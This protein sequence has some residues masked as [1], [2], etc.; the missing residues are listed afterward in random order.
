MKIILCPLKQKERQQEKL[1]LCRTISH[2]FIQDIDVMILTPFGS[3]KRNWISCCLFIHSFSSHDAMW[4]KKVEVETWIFGSKIFL[5]ISL[6]CTK[7]FCRDVSQS[8]SPK[9][10]W[11]LTCSSW[12]IIWWH[13]LSLQS[14]A[15]LKEAIWRVCLKQMQNDKYNQCD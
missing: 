4:H 12:I 2:N 5:K 10:S 6:G 14:R 1:M 7:H 8:Q 11:V 3:A 15:L 13:A 9:W